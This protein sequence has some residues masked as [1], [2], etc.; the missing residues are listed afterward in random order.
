[1][2]IVRK[3]LERV[4]QGGKVGDAF[5]ACK[6][7]RRFESLPGTRI[8]VLVFECRRCRLQ[9]CEGVLNAQQRIFERLCVVNPSVS[10]T[11]V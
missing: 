7:S 2:V 3:H 10:A 8:E 1:M 4:S 6:R 9:G 11:Q 5:V